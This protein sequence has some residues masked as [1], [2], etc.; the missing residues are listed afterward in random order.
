MQDP[1]K[2]T[3][4]GYKILVAERTDPGWITAIS[5]ADGIVVEYGSLLSHTAIVARELGI[6]TIVAAAGVT[7]SLKTGDRVRL[8]GASGQVDLLKVREDLAA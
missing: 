4:E 1:N 5:S 8:D 6:P 7:K 3:M 2:E